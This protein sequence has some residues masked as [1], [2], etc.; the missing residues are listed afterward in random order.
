[1]SAC[2]CVCVL[3][4]MEREEEKKKTEMSHVPGRAAKCPL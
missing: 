2:V 4:D 3:G 1:M